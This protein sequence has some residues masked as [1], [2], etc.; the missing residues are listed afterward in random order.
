MQIGIMQWRFNRS[1]SYKKRN[2]MLFIFKLK[3]TKEE[4]VLHTGKIRNDQYLLV[5]SYMFLSEIAL[6]ATCLF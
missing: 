3:L 5:F 2:S 1:I 4:K 6:F